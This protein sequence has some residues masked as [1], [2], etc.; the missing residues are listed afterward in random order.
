MPTKAERA[1]YWNALI[2][3]QAASGLTQADFCKLRGV[4]IHTFRERR[5]RPRTAPRPE[6]DADRRSQTSARFIPVRLKSHHSGAE[7]APAPIEIRLPHGYR[8]AVESQFDPAALAKILKSNEDIHT[9]RG[10][11]LTRPIR[12]H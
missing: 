2:E 7:P 4:S 10:A 5:Y 12:V 11:L 3:E 8:V 9:S 1:Q 6:L